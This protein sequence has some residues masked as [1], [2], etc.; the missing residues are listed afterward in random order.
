M[1]NTNNAKVINIVT[2]ALGII[3]T[4]AAVPA[5][6]SLPEKVPTHFDAKWVCDDIGSRWSLLVIAFIPLIMSLILTIPIKL[7]MKQQPKVMAITSLV[8]T[9][10]FCAMFWLLY[11]IAASD[12]QIGDKLDKP[13][14]TVFLP[15]LFAALFIVLGNYIPVVK[16]NRFFGLR[17]KWTLENPQ[18]WKVTHRFMGKLM[19]ITGVIAFMISIVAYALGVTNPIV[20]TGTVLLMTTITIVLSTLYAYKHKSDKLLSK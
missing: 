5:I 7:K 1:K 12:L 14:F 20:E 15:M 10:F 4:I 16:H 13:P 11:P 17:V 18:C 6:L 3:N 19:V 9:L 2:L 8:C